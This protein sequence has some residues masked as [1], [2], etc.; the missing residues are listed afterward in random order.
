MRNPISPNIQDQGEESPDKNLAT[1]L[2]SV[3]NMLGGGSPTL[4]S[5][6]IVH[7]LLWRYTSYELE[8]LQLTGLENIIRLHGGDIE[9]RHKASMI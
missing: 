5:P 3:S 1:P 4:E 9:R 8:W 7:L 6:G 2:K